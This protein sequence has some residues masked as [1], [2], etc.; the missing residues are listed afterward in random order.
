MLYKA[1]YQIRYLLAVLMVLLPVLPA[2]QGSSLPADLIREAASQSAAASPGLRQFSAGGHILGVQ[3]SGIYIASANHSLHI[4]FVGANLVQPQA[5]QPA[6]DSTSAAVDSAKE[7]AQPLG[8]VSWPGLWEGISLVYQAD[9]GGIAESVYTLAPESAAANIRLCYHAPASLDSSGALVLSFPAGK[10]TESAPVA[11]QEIGG[12]RLPV[13][14]SFRILDGSDAS[15]TQVGFAIGSYDPAYPLVI[16]PRLT[17]TKF[18]GGGTQDD[19]E[20]KS[21]AVDSTGNTYLAGISAIP[22]GNPNRAYSSPDDAFVAKLDASG[23]LQWNTFLGGSGNDIATGVAVD[24]YGNVLVAGTSDAAWGASSYPYIGSKDAWVSKLD[25]DGLLQW[26]TFLGSSLQDD[27]YGI[28]VDSS[29]NPFVVGDSA[30]TWGTPI[31]PHSGGNDAFVAK[32]AGITGAVAW[33]TFMGGTMN[34]YGYGIAL[35]STNVYITGMSSS[36]WGSPGRIFTSNPDAFA[37]KLNI[38]SGVRVWNTFLGG[39][40]YDVGLSI[41]A[42]NSGVV[43]VAGTTTAAWG[44]PERA[45]SANSDGWVVRLESNGELTWSTFLGGAGVDRADGIA[46]DSYGKVYVSGGTCTNNWGVPIIAFHGKCAAY[47]AQINGPDGVLYWNTF[48]NGSGADDTS[49]ASALAVNSGG[50]YL[51]GS[52]EQSWGTPVR[53]FT[54][55]PEGFVQMLALDGILSWNTFVGGSADDFILGMS[56]DASG[57]SY[58]TGYSNQPWG[59]PKNAYTGKNDAFA[60]KLN[61]NGSLLWSTF[62]GSDLNDYGYSIALGNGKVFVAGTSSSTWGTP[63]RA[64]TPGGSDGFVAQLDPAN[65]NLLWNTFLGGTGGDEAYHLFVESTSGDVYV[66]GYSNASWGLPARSYTSAGDAFVARL[67][68]AGALAWNTFLG[69][70]STDAGYGII[71]DTAG[72]VDVVG[73][74]AATWGTPVQPFSAGIDG[75]AA[76]LDQ[77][78]GA[79]QWNTFL[80]G[81]GTDEATAITQDYYARLVVAGDSTGGWGMPEGNTPEGGGGNTNDFV[82]ELIPST[83][84]VNW[85][86]F[87]GGSG[88]ESASNI[89]VD[90]DGNVYLT[91]V[92]NL[93]WYAPESLPKPGLLA[94][95][96]DSSPAG[97]LSPDGGGGGTPSFLTQLDKD[98]TVHWTDFLTA[99]GSVYAITVGIDGS[100][101]P[102]VAG[103]SSAAWGKY[104]SSYSGGWDGFVAKI[105]PRAF[106]FLPEVKK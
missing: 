69:G 62:L 33:N 88:N 13:Q 47:V 73:S 9:P 91:G 81:A 32:L 24:T 80:G 4:E 11:W 83:G 84:A 101:N 97:S 59:Y 39:T 82:A 79:L 18:L 65:G 35:N 93:T 49:S 100:G 105:D 98:G 76:R 85:T 7:P 106:V 14:A 43:Y 99:P 19:D 57:N 45:Y 64:F 22:W 55:A 48:L 21:I 34:D 54:G 94:Q 37:A 52:S 2:G 23:V 50:V 42:D 44:D 1:Y 95:T 74:S 16:D 6:P 41:D 67:S 26:T 17:W 46:I 56:V 60:A 72:Y 63:K 70:S 29:G 5:S 71:R 104:A 78:T 20:V 8:Q 61:Y 30:G 3:E 38:T 75:F 51:A 12:Q 15:A 102:Y 86:T 27:A 68:S 103:Y 77:T 36:S 31:A 90:L 25:P 92:T 96:G 58:V 53:A 40:G 66:T 89:A 28:A 87:I 10:M